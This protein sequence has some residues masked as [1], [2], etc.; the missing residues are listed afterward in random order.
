LALD[1]EYQDLFRMQNVST[2][3][4][5]RINSDEEERQKLGYEIQTAIRFGSSFG[6]QSS[7]IGRLVIDGKSFGVLTYA[8]AATITR[9]NLGWRR[10]QPKDR[11][12]FMMD[13]EWGRWERSQ[14]DEEEEGGVDPTQMRKPK[15]VIPFVEDRRNSLIL[16]P[17]ML[18]TPEQMASLQSAL[19]V[20]IQR[21][22][23]LEDRELAVESLPSME[24]RKQILFYESSEGGAGVLKRLVEEQE[25]WTKVIR[26]AL[27]ICHYDP[28]TG[29]D[30]GMA[31]HA[32]ENCVAACY[33]CLLSYYNQWDHPILDRREIRDILIALRNTSLESSPVGQDRSAHLEQLLRRADSD[34]EKKWVNL[35]EK[36]HLRLPDKSQELMEGCHTRPDF[37]YHNHQTVIYVDGSPHQFPERQ[38][39]DQQ[40][41]NCLEDTGYTVLRFGLEDD[42]LV[43]FKKYPDIFGRLD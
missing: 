40:Q 3:R 38:Q 14:E 43:I 11:Y 21:E 17:E 18:L 36:H 35:L 24:E 16:Q 26:K 6:Q 19:K 2:R 1:Y 13:L 42:W 20:A 8:Q 5:Q 28:E 34:L 12:G 31:P 25:L 39:R 9:I 27:E 7:L 32:R 23:Q 33:D 37:I 4:V 15:R 30:L 10:R 29:A 22:F 41:Q